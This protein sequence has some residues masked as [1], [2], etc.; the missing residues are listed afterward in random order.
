M[1]SP[2]QQRKKCGRVGEE[3]AQRF[4]EARGYRV[5]EVNWHSRFGEID[6]IAV[7]EGVMHFCEVKSRTSVAFGTPEEAVN[8]KKLHKIQKT[9]QCYLQEHG[10]TP[11]QIDI[12]AIY[13]TS[14]LAPKKITHYRNI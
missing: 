4:L 3:I 14:T 7:K 1:Q 9:I 5:V 2:D 10:F 11:W 12:F 8:R 13:L 6:I